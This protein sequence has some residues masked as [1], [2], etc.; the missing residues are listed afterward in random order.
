[1]KSSSRRAELDSPTDDVSGTRRREPEIEIDL[2]SVP[3]TIAELPTL[4]RFAGYELLGRVA[5]GGMAEIFLARERSGAGSTR[6]VALKVVRPELA[7]DRE[8]TELFLREGKVALGLRH[9]SVCHVYE[10][11]VEQGHPFLAMELVTGVTVRELI[12]RAR[13]SGAPIPAPIA[14]KIASSVAEALH[15]A[16]VAQD[17]RGRSLGIVHQDVSPHNVMVAYD[18]TVKL[19]DFGVATTTS[20]RDVEAEKSHITVRG[21]AGYLSPEQ[22]RG[23]PVDARSDV[24]SLGVVLYEMLTGSR[25]SV[26]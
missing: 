21:K 22:C 12:T 25:K 11:G 26:V 3:A 16:H 5:I 7:A 20:E 6:L 4:R 13:R 1:M 15:S 23:V 14:A 17:E 18:G 19:L 9:P 24:F 8:L 10:F 2:S